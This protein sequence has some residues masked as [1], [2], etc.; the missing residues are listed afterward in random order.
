MKKIYIILLL[1]VPFSF[2]SC[3]FLDDVDTDE[4]TIEEV[5]EGLKTALMVGTDTSVMKTSAFDGYYGDP[6]IKIPL[7]EEAEFISNAVQEYELFET[8][9]LRT[10]IEDK[11]DDL[12]LAVNRAA[13]DAAS[14]AAPI[15]KNA[16]TS[17]TISDAWDILT[18]YY[19]QA[20]NNILGM[21]AGLEP[22]NTDIGEFT[23]GKALD[24]LFLKVGEEEVK[25]RRDPWAWASE[26]VGD[27]LTK[28]FGGEKN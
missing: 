8:L 21:L 16:I 14:D 2:H 25:I 3:D 9:G 19:N 5:V 20:A 22:I 24:G 28:V 10:L 12:V 26:T 15:F 23:V 18:S 4:L 13:E 27:I 17:L 7:P 1:F 11:L 6:V